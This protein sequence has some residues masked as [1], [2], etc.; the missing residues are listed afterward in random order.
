MAAST[1]AASST[2]DQAMLRVCSRLAATGVVL[3]AT[4]NHFLRDHSEAASAL[5]YQASVTCG[6][7]GSRERAIRAYVRERRDRC[8]CSV[9]LVYA[10]VFGAGKGCESRSVL[11]AIARRRMQRGSACGGHN[12]IQL[13]EV[14]SGSVDKDEHLKTRGRVP[15]HQRLGA[16]AH[17]AP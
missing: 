15:P 16:A 14:G 7:D 1:S 12:L 8:P 2:L 4:D 10:G 9:Q 3:I 5:R 13:R 6:G 11:R 17:A